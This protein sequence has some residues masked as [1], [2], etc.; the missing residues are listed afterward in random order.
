[1][2]LGRIFKP[3]DRDSIAYLLN[4]V[5]GQALPTNAF[6][7]IPTFDI[8]GEDVA[9]P[10]LIFHESDHHEQYFFTRLKKDN[11]HD[12]E[13]SR[14]SGKGVWAACGGERMIFDRKGAVLGL[15]SVFKYEGQSNHEW[16][17]KEYT[18]ANKFK[19]SCVRTEYVDFVFCMVKRNPRVQIDPDK[20]NEWFLDNF[21]DEI[22]KQ[23]RSLSLQRSSSSA[24]PCH[25]S[26]V[27]EST[28]NKRI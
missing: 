18:L 22:F 19:Y 9:D 13:Y 15:W 23:Q 12:G 27:A 16:F 3:S 11:E 20:R 25:D 4:M 6:I 10:S 8:Y 7:F 21:F 26:T 2:E 14:T 24:D 17:L 1:M 5:S 28:K